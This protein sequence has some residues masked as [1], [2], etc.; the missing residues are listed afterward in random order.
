VL[1]WLVQDFG[2]FGLSG[3]N[4]MPV[5]AG[6]LLLYVVVMMVVRRGTR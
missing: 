4:W 5:L 2:F 6:A 3:Q 1:N